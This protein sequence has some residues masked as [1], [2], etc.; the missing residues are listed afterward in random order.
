MKVA[1]LFVK[2]GLTGDKKVSSG[3]SNVNK[4]MSS[5]VAK[6]QLMAQAITEAGKAFLKFS[7]MGFEAG[8]E[9]TVFSERT[10]LSTKKLQQFQ[11]AG[12]QMGLS[13]KGLTSNLLSLHQKM[14][15]ITALGEVKTEGFA[16]M[17]QF[18]DFDE[19]KAQS[20][21]FYL[22]Q[23]A[24]EFAQ[25]AL[26][27]G[28]S[29]GFVTSILGNAGFSEDMFA[30]LLSGVFNEKNFRNA[31]IIGKGE[32]KRLHQTGVAF[33][34]LGKK[35]NRAM[36]GLTG[37][38][39][40]KIIKF[41]N[42]LIPPITD[43][44]GAL[45]TFADKAK[46]FEIIALSMKGIEQIINGFLIALEKFGLVE[47]SKDAEKKINGG[48]KE[49]SIFGGFGKF[50]KDNFR[51]AKLDVDTLR[52]KQENKYGF[53]SVAPTITVN[54]NQNIVASDPSAVSSAVNRGTSKAVTDSFNQVNKNRI[55]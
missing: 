4:G 45:L 19:S 7:Q 50:L 55:D 25:T 35:I 54:N 21:V 46:V 5:A 18:V 37:K 11:Y 53:K 2:L 38:H 43:L 29:R 33:S 26:A 13:A 17:S 10:G 40:G 15:D 12:E 47:I 34:N 8:T 49:S 23:K 24:Q 20:D 22:V 30:P 36:I 48:S 31:P 42:Q 16:Y 51:A 52:K 44:I 3:L 1:E 39:A 41:V 9:I 6:G 27:K 28:K 14:S 32:A